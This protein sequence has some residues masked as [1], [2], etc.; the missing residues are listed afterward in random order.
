MD[1]SIC[2]D[3]NLSQKDR[4]REIAGSDQCWFHGDCQNAGGIDPT[5][6][7]SE[8]A[9][10]TV[11]PAW[12]AASRIL[13]WVQLD[14]T[15][16]N[17]YLPIRE[18]I[19]HAGTL[20][21][22]LAGFFAV[23]VAESSLAGILA[24]FRGID[25]YVRLQQ[26]TRWEGE[27]E[28]IKRKTLT[29]SS[30]VLF[31]FGTINQKLAQLLQPFDCRIQSF[32]SDWQAGKLDK[33]LES[34][35]IIV[36]AAPETPATCRVFDRSRLARLKPGA[37]F[38]NFGRGSVVDEAEL[39]RLLQEQSIGGAVIDVTEEE[40]LPG[41]HAFWQCPNIILTQHSGGG[42]LDETGR[43]IEFFASNLERY[44]AGKTPACL[45]DLSR[46]Y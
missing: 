31:G 40:P 25:R 10:G 26:E 8:V 28:R 27:T 12:V 20:V 29:N 39:V 42:D 9:F 43:K 32:A 34:A 37:L 36:C 17:Q 21:S 33:A 5:F 14:S 15:G 46:G 44:R 13:K 41:D 24:F 35:D 7:R 38:V 2:L 4:L 23:P 11:P 19:N 16:I 22:N 30:V 6:L 1:I 18:T 45:V 3:L